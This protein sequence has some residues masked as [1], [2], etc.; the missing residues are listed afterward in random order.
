MQDITIYDENYKEVYYYTQWDLDR[1][2]YVKEADLGDKTVDF[3]HFFNPNSDR[4]LVV[5]A[6]THTSSDQDEYYYAKIPNI[7][8]ESSVPIIGYTVTNTNVGG[9]NKDRAYFKFSITVRKQP[10]PSDRISHSTDEQDYIDAVE[11]LE[12]VRQYAEDCEIYADRAEQA[13]KNAGY[14]YMYINED[15]DL[16]YDRTDNVNVN[17]YLDSGDLYM[18]S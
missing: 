13:A 15:G 2:V 16:I 3:F 10:Q 12:E 18:H 6:Q 4:A 7:L 5:E 11:I 17:F 1:Y 14:M 9:E 8:L